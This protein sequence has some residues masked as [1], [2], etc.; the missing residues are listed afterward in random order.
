MVFHYSNIISNL[1][2]TINKLT[3]LFLIIDQNFYYIIVKILFG[4]VFLSRRAKNTT[5][6]IFLLDIN[7]INN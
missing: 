5:L 1:T 2:N 4:L 7:I 3:T 6:A